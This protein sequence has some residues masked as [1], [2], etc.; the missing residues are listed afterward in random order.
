MFGFF[1]L[2]AFK[3]GKNIS[4]NR[5]IWRVWIKFKTHTWFELLSHGY[6]VVK[7]IFYENVGNLTLCGGN[8][9]LATMIQLVILVFM[10]KQMPQ[11]KRLQNKWQWFFI[12]TCLRYVLWYFKQ[13]DYFQFPKQSCA[14][15]YF[16]AFAHAGLPVW[17]FCHK[18]YLFHFSWLTPIYPS[19]RYLLRP[20]FLP[21][22]FHGLN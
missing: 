17:M 5:N 21:E 7:L 19:H 6:T 22:A 14:L 11:I 1:L 16:L 2:L 9:V 8:W 20:Y 15:S 10:P 12:F 3:G 4:I 18:I 13:P